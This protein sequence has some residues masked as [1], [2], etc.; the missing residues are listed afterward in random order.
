MLCVP[1]KGLQ[2]SRILTDPDLLNIPV[3]EATPPVG[4]KCFTEYLRAVGYYCT[5]NAKSDYQFQPPITAWDENNNKAHWRNRPDPEM[6]FF[7]VF[8]F[9]ITHESQIHSPPSPEVTNPDAIEVPPY[10]PNTPTVRKDIAHHYDNVVTLDQQIEKVLNQLKEDGLYEK[11]IIFFYGDHGDGLPRAKRWVYDSGI[12]V[13][14]IIRFPEQAHAATR[15]ERLV[16]FVDFAPTIL[17]LLNIAIPLHMEGQ[18]F[19]GEAMTPTRKYIYASRD[20]MDPA[21]E[22]IRAVRDTRFKYI[23]NY[24]P[25]LPYIGFIP[26][27]DRMLMMQEI[28][29]LAAANKLGPDQ[30]QILGTK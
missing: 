6:P 7:S 11:T 2:R 29:Q 8:N 17:S 24:R 5:N 25:D 14:L 3:Y 26:Y 13:P 21:Y 30:W 19:L 10:Y 22:T 28:K 18:A 23:R 1:G 4:A 9:G 20:R 15:E 16:S 12:Q 27:R